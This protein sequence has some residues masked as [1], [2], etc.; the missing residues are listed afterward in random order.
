MSISFCCVCGGEEFASK[1][2]LWPE[3]VENWGLLPQE[4]EYINR[5]QGFHCLS[6]SNNLRSIALSSAILKAYRYEGT[7]AQF[8]CSELASSLKVLEVNEAGGLTSLLERLPHHRL[9]KYPEHDLTNLGLDSRG[10]DLVV[11]SD[12]L[13]H[14][15][16]PLAGLTECR[17]VLNEN[18]RCI[19]TVPIVIGRLSRSRSGLSNSYHGSQA[20][21][22]HNLLVHT[23]FGSDVWTYVFDAGFQS[24]TMH[25]V[26]Y[27][28]GIAIEASG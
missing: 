3:L 24:A 11:H 4:V 19:F 9:I 21:S 7:L 25:C 14:V 27:P 18:G 6:C 23:E 13:E 1:D 28:A 20:E 16:D 26:D 10:F 17:R 15:E 5:Q 2:V 22:S 12:T 8:V